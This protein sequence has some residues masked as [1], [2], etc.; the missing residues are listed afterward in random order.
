V[1]ILASVRKKDVLELMKGF[2]LF[3]FQG[4]DTPTLAAD[5]RFPYLVYGE[6]MD[7]AGLLAGRS[8]QSRGFVRP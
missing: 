8:A 7:S 2:C 1:A 5:A 4:R 3:G 6:S